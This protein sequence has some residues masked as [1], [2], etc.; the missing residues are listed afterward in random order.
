M[1]LHTRILAKPSKTVHFEAFPDAG[2]PL[3]YY[4]YRERHTMVDKQY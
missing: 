2:L 4:L 1:E 3:Y